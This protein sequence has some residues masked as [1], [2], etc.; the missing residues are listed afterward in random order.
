MARIGTLKGR[1]LRVRRDGELY[2]YSAGALVE[3][4]QSAGVTTDEAMKIVSG[5]EAQIRE[6]KLRKIDLSAL[7]DMLEEGAKHRSV[8]AAERLRRQTPPFVPIVVEDV[9]SGDAPIRPGSLDI[10]RFSRRTLMASLEKLGLKLKEAHTATAQVEQA[11]RAEGIEKLTRAELA[12]RVAS[13]IE[14]RHGREARLRYE[15]QTH[16]PFEIRVSLGAGNDMPYSRGI[17][18]RSLM[19]VGLGPDFSHNLAKR[20]EEALYARDADVVSPEQVRSEVARLV[21]LEAGDEYA[22]RYLLM[23]EMRTSERPVIVV[24]GGAPGVGKSAIASEVGY[25]LGIPR[26]VST[27]SIREALRSLISPELSPV[28]HSSS[29]MAWREELMPR[30][31]SRAKPSRNRVL[32]GL[33]AQANQLDPALNAIIRRSISEDQSLVIEGVHLIPGTSPTQ[34]FPEATIIQMVLYVPDPD[35]HRSHFATREVRSGRRQAGPYVEH[36]AEIR[37]MQEFMHQ[38]ADLE[39]VPSVDASGFDSAVE[40]CV[41][42]VLDVLLLEQAQREMLTGKSEQRAAAGGR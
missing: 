7:V 36:F 23:R 28:L 4:L 34:E 20:V 8:Q 6:R 35:D 1:D 32:R 41:D 19:A 17:L 10:K 27:D 26:I 30:E 2:P 29:F 18:A 13:V 16:R 24:I 42:L 39:G 40:R 11:L 31:R 21:R 37:M 15:A 5:I 38:Q 25:R 33:L 9:S 12:R 3:S 14:V 22:R